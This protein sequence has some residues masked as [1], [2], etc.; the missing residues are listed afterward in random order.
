MKETTY[1]CAI[2]N[3]EHASIQDRINCETTCLKKQ[4]EAERIAAEAKK[5]A[6]KDVRQ[7]EVS[8]AIDNTLALV[9]KFIEDYG[10]Y[11]YNGKTK[12]LNIANLDFLPSKLLHHFWF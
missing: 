3:T 4:A 5:K 8:A 9:N 10:S 11:Q 12:D 1:K 2:C 6:E 7:Q